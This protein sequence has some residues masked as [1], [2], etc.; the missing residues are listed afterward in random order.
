MR[1]SRPQRWSRWP[2]SILLAANAVSLT[3]NMLTTVAVPWFVLQ[4][5]GSAERAGL[6]AFAA[7]LPIVISAVFGGALV[8]RIG[9]RRASILSDLLSGVTVAA[10]PALYLTTGLA[11]WALLA[12]LFVRWLL[13]TPGETAREALVLDI[14]DRGKI[15]IERATAAREGV[16][17]G[18]RMLG[19]PLAGVLIAALGPA[20]L[21]FVDAATFLFSAALMGV[22]ARQGECAGEGGAR[23]SGDYVRSLLE[24]FAF[25]WRE[26]LLRG[27]VVMI[28]VTN[29]LDIGIHQV[30]MPVY[31]RDVLHDPRGLGLLEGTFSVGAVAGT[32]AYGALGGRL[33]RRLTY[34]VCFLLTVPRVFILSMDAPFTLVLLVTFVSG[35]MAGGINPLLGVIKFE[36]IPAGLRARVLGAMVAG[37][38]VAMP[39][40]GLLAGS[41]TEMFGLSTTLLVFTGMYFAVCVPPF[42]GRVW[43]ELDMSSGRGETGCP[44][45]W[46]GRRR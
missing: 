36:C 2:L 15:K 1:R 23:D 29:M 16:S 14:A 33:P 38:Y 46:S 13:A 26:R 45:A 31:A 19:A 41:L 27:I 8:D 6:A 21:L 32:V 37:A 10:M 30:L 12:L 4:T 11:F 28:V 34:S 7:T 40:G 5:T 9:R 3:G 18:A 39:A 44:A 24:G 25:L 43:R 35:A 42:I 22:G 20:A 17:R